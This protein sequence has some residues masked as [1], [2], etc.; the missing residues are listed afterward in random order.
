[1]A[2]RYMGRHVDHAVT[3]DWCRKEADDIAFCRI[4]QMGMLRLLSSP[5]I[6]G[7]D[8]ID[9]SQAW[10][11]YDQL[12]ADERVIRGRFAAELD[13]VWQAISARDDK[14]HKL[15]TNPGLPSSLCPGQ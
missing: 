5:A 10:R 11:T 4:T 14:S 8:A 9:R 15:W 1:M 2:G 7:E 3:A 12:W 13:A 6:T